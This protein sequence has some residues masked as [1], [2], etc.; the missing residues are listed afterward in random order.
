MIPDI[1]KNDIYDIRA[2]SPR[3]YTEWHTAPSLDKALAVWLL[4]STKH[5]GRMVTVEISNTSAK[6]RAME[7]E[8]WCIVEGK[9]QKTR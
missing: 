7:A 2:F 1:R 4:L 6:I 3:M 5:S 8:G 9:W